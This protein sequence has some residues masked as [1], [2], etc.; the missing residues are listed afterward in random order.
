MKHADALKLCP[1]RI[2]IIGNKKYIV[3]AFNIFSHDE[4]TCWLLLV[5]SEIKFQKIAAMSFPIFACS[6][7][8]KREPV[9]RFPWNLILGTS[10]ILVAIF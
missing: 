6:Q 10:L 3:T 7:V 9:K 4:N 8:A 5:L 1:N 2:Y